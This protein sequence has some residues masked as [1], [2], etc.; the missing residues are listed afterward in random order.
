MDSIGLRLPQSE[1]PDSSIPLYSCA[2]KRL[3]FLLLLVVLP[4]RLA[5]AVGAGHC[6]PDAGLTGGVVPVAA[7]SHALG[8]QVHGDDGHVH[9]DESRAQ[10]HDPIGAGHAGD[11]GHDCHLLQLVALEPPAGRAQ[12]L[13][14]IGT[15]ACEREQPPYE[16]HIPAGPERPKWPLAA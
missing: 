13:L 7:A 2:V 15:A 11:S 3:V 12:S 6:P 16:S 9:G 5:W 4:L 8:G 14:G 1:F 10:G